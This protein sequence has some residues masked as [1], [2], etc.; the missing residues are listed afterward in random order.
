MRTTVVCVGLSHVLDAFCSAFVELCRL[1]LF[2]SACM[3]AG[4]SRLQESHS[5][6]HSLTAAPP[7]HPHACGVCSTFCKA[8]HYTR[9]LEALQLNLLQALQQMCPCAHESLKLSPGARMHPS[10]PPL[11]ASAECSY[12]EWFLTMHHAMSHAQACFADQQRSTA[13]C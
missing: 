13:A 7:A 5:W 12:C 3:H 8:G 11:C 1:G 4:C 9:I 6:D 10:C 2:G